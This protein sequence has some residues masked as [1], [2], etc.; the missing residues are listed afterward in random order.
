MKILPFIFILFAINCNAQM[1]ANASINANYKGI[2][3]LFLISSLDSSLIITTFKCGRGF[4][5]VVLE[6]KLEDKFKE[7]IFSCDGREPIDSGTWKIFDN[8]LL[9]GKLSYELFRFGSLY[10]LI[11]ISQKKKIH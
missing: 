6:I 1:Q 7:S 8:K 5:G 11:E 9:I 10:Y 4:E 2:E 3:G